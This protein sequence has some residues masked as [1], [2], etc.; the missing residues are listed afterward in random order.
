MKLPN[1]PPL[2][3]FG[4]GEFR[5]INLRGSNGTSE[6]VLDFSSSDKLHGCLHSNIFNFDSIMSLAG[7]LPTIVGDAGFLPSISFVSGLRLFL[8]QTRIEVKPEEV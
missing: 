7:V 2:Q 8:C 6:V 1:F 4:A 3:Y 5:W